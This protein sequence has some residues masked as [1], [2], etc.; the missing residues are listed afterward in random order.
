MAFGM[1]VCSCGKDETPAVN[2]QVTGTWSFVNIHL[3]TFYKLGN[4]QT[5][6]MNV[7]TFNDVSINNQGELVIDSGKIQ[8]RS[9]TYSAYPFLTQPYIWGAVEIIP[10]ST[11]NIPM[12]AVHLPNIS[13]P[14][15][16]ISND[17]LYQGPAETSAA[18]GYSV[19][20]TGDTLILGSKASA[21][22]DTSYRYAAQ[23]MKFIKKK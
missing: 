6:Y 21:I 9:I 15:K 22:T 13:A 11:S 20:W 2:N 18:T 5:P 16:M 8:Y 1:L 3:H 7:Y 17:S 23:Q 19:A 12:D 4:A 14:Y 10:D